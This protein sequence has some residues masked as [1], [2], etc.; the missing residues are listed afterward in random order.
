MRLPVQKLPDRFL[1]TPICRPTTS[2]DL[3]RPAAN[4]VAEDIL[5][6]G[7]HLSLI[8]GIICGVLPSFGPAR[9]HD[10]GLPND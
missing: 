6:R 2:Y 3:T 1:D 5:M 8:F 4:R 10:D 9:R 7:G